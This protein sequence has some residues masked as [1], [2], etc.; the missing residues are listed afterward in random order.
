MPIQKI[1]ET[2][3]SSSPSPD[4]HFLVTQPE[5][6][7]AGKLVESLRRIG[8]DDIANMLKEKFGLGDTAKELASLKEEISKHIYKTKMLNYSN[9]NNTKTFTLESLGLVIGD[10][11][12][13]EIT[14]TGSDLKSISVA[15]VTESSEQISLVTNL[16]AGDIGHITIPNDAVSLRVLC[17]RNGT[18]TD[19]EYYTI[20]LYKYQF[21]N[22]SLK[23]FRKSLVRTQS[24]ISCIQNNI[25]SNYAIMQNTVA[26]SG[27]YTKDISELGI[28][29]GKA[30]FYRITYSNPTNLER[31]TISVRDVDGNGLGTVADYLSDG[32]IG[33]IT[34]PENTVKIRLLF[35]LVSNEDAEKTIRADFWQFSFDEY[36]KK[37]LPQKK[38][39]CCI[40][41]S[42]TAGNVSWLT[43]IAE[44][45]GYD[46]VNL[47]VAGTRMTVTYT[48]K[49]TEYVSFIDRVKN[50]AFDSYTPDL[51]I[52]FGGINDTVKYHNGQCI[53]GNV[54]DAPEY[55]SA[56]TSGYSFISRV[57]YLIE[58]I[59]ST[60]Q[61]VPILGVIPPNYSEGISDYE[62][63]SEYISQIQDALRSVYEYYGILYVDLKKTC[64]EMYEDSYNLATYRI[65]GRSNMH[66][67][68]KGHKAIG[69][70][71]EVD[72]IN[73]MFD[74]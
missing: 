1:T 45:L 38:Q 14:Y 32:S 60:K 8:A 74:D 7:E 41:D 50:G 19:K 55:D 2:E 9:E 12:T 26:T 11:V 58:L 39:I 17:Y 16:V 27:I 52:I 43:Y 35:H 3:T 46:M 56:V 22:E 24:E 23:D 61:G 48:S 53:I 20:Y 28:G 25:F 40:G 15:Y 57:K 13:Y 63:W 72:G 42:F 36:Y 30:Y 44:R 65:D 51:I 5:A 54:E 66:P 62:W 69:K 10:E 29:V 49:N 4:T 6:N 47:G 21:G 37:V 34:I 59:K 71:I 73:K 68:V 33:V 18:N 64:Q 70:R 67:S 31:L